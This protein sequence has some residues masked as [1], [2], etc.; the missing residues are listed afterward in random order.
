MSEKAD[1]EKE[2]EEFLKPTK[3]EW[4]EHLAEAAG[5]PTDEV[6]RIKKEFREKY[7]VEQKP[8]KVVKCPRCGY[9]FTLN[10]GDPPDPPEI[11]EAEYEEARRRAFTIRGPKLFPV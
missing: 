2:L 9:E 7:G 4:E 3:V 10:P 11:E 5:P 6:E 1:W 8:T